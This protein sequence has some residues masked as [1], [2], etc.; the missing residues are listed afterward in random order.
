MTETPQCPDCHAEME[1]GFIPDFAYSQSTHAVYQTLWHPGTAEDRHFLGLRT[2][3]VKIDK[4]E[5]IKIVSFRCR[6]C[7]LLRD[8]AKN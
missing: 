6:K 5:A 4:T 8:Y 7:G 1:S 3:A 2:G